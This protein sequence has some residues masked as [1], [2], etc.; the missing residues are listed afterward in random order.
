MTGTTRTSEGL[1]ERRRRLLYRAWHRGMR[2]MDLIMG[3]FADAEIG[4]MSEADLDDVRAAER[5]AGPRSLQL[6]RQQCRRAGRSTIPRCCAGCARSITARDGKLMATAAKSPAELLAPGRPLT[7]A[8]VA[9]GAEGL[10]VADLARAIAAKA[11]CAGDEPACGLPR[12]AAHGAACR[13]RWSFSR[14]TS[15][16]RNFRHGT[17]SPTTASRR[18]PA[19]SRSA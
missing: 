18:M 15:S 2:E 4:D 11:E 13:A 8:N 16:G 3:R 10:A 7:L 19:S 6:D 17:A 9:D 14:R 1:D 5:G 12:R